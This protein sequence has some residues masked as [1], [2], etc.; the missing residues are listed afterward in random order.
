MGVQ[1]SVDLCNWNTAATSCVWV[2][3]LEMS[4]GSEW[5][6]THQKS[7][8][9]FLV[10]CGFFFLS[11]VWN[12][13]VFSI[14]VC[15]LEPLTSTRECIL[16]FLSWR[17]ESNRL[18]LNWLNFYFKS[19]KFLFLFSIVWDKMSVEKMNGTRKE[20]VYFNFP[21]WGMNNPHVSS[22]M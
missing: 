11:L 17:C 19:V 13:E 1:F 21:R 15:R 6:I 8:D 3:A 12:C 22:G 20:G 18:A 7:F 9:R 4:K 14:Y 10:F 16:T 5:K 2:V